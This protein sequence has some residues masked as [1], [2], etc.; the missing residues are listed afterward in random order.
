MSRVPMRF[1]TEDYME[2]LNDVFTSIHYDRKIPYEDDL[3]KE[4]PYGSRLWK[5]EPEHDPWE[6]LAA[7]VISHAAKDYVEAC[8][9]KDEYGK[10]AIKRWFMQNDFKETIFHELDRLTKRVPLHELW[11]CLRIFW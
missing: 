7:A 8:M 4:A 11:R 5:S 1:G 2:Y 10:E 3:L 6:L 9:D